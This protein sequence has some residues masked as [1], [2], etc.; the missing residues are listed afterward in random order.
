[1]KLDYDMT[2]PLKVYNYFL[3]E[4]VHLAAEA[5]FDGLV[6]KNG[7]DAE[8]NR[9][10]MRDLSKVRKAKD[11][12]TKKLNGKRA[13]KALTIVGI[14][15]FFLAAI[16]VLVVGIYNWSTAWWLIFVSLGCIAVGVGLIFVITK[17]LKKK[18]QALAER[19]AKLQAKADE[20]LQ[21]A[22]NQMEPLNRTRLNI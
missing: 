16:V 7:I 4:D 22:R 2:E 10:L 6:L 3:K 13:L 21:E 19:V 11:E 5:Y 12:F 14:I 17:V 9:Q 20:I 8:Y 15:L 1:M 18:I